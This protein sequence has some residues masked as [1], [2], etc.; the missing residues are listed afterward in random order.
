MTYAVLINNDLPVGNSIF[1]IKTKAHFLHLHLA[2][3]TDA[4]DMLRDLGTQP[5]LDQSAE[6]AIWFREIANTWP[7]HV[8]SLE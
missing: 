5:S 8:M 2:F 1:E 6:V 3:Q 4:G 7:M